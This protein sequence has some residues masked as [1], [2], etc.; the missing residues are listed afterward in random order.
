MSDDQ[1]PASADISPPVL[2]LTQPDEANSESQSQSQQYPATACPTLGGLAVESS[3]D[4]M[5]INLWDPVPA[6]NDPL[7]FL[8]ENVDLS[9]LDTSI[10]A[11]IFE[12]GQPASTLPAHGRLT[13]GLGLSQLPGDSLNAPSE[14]DTVQKHWFTYIARESSNPTSFDPPSDPDHVDERYRADLVQRLQ[15]GIHNSFLPSVEFLVMHRT[16]QPEYEY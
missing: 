6:G 7:W 14:E 8:G 1:A 2:H 13:D 16:P 4:A 9:A 5:D 11:T 12:W 15:P 3:S 10:S